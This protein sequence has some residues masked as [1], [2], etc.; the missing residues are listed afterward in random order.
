MFIPDGYG[1]LEVICGPM[2]SGKS[3]ELIRRIRRA[4]I[5]KQKVVVFK[6]AI[7]D[8]YDEECI[9]SHDGNNVEGISIVNAEEILKYIDEDT[10][11]IGIDEV[12][13]IEGNTQDVIK[14]LVDQGKRVICAGLD[15]DFKGE[16]FGCVPKLLAVADIVTKLTAVCMTCSH[17]ANLTQRL[18]D[19]KPAKYHDPLIVIGAQES[20]E[21]RCRKCHSVPKE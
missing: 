12:Q 8:R 14:A 15:M 4:K 6:P 20:Y 5:G 2:F 19:G 11:V 18:V 7:D 16:P 10:K 1:I 9:C 13:F 3:E 17:P 21:A